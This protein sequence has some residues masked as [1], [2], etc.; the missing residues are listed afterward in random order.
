MKTLERISKYSSHDDIDSEGSWAISYGDMVT[1]LLCFFILFF[2]VDP[3]NTYRENLQQAILKILEQ[4]TTKSSQQQVAG[5]A[6]TMSLGKLPQPGMDEN[7]LKQWPGVPHKIGKKILVEFP[8][9][10]F[11]NF[12]KVELTKDGIITLRQFY[13]KY[14]PYAGQNKLVIRAFTDRKQVLNDNPRYKDN[15]ELSALRSVAAMRELSKFGLPLNRMRLGGYGE[16]QWTP[17]ELESIPIE[18]RPAAMLDLARRIVLVIEPIE[19][20]L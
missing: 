19:V 9:V 14:L 6:P 8:G 3:T 20:D 17:T 11:F 7:I 1:L 13:E 10:S 16:F 12:S 15:L 4:N 5:E 2:S 18:R